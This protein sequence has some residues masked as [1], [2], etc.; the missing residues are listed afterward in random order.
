MSRIIE[1]TFSVKHDFVLALCIIIGIHHLWVIYIYIL[2]IL[3]SNPHLN[4]IHTSFCRFLKRKK[5]ARGSN[6]HLSFNRPL[7][8]RQT[9]S[10]MSDDGESDE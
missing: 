4:L 9:D 6:L 3:E 10:V 2:Y 7:P 1:V 5:L 8:T